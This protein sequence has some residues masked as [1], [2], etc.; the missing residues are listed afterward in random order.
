M[1]AL[2][3]DD[4]RSIARDDAATPEICDSAKTAAAR[5]LAKEAF[6]Q[7]TTA[8]DYAKIQG[9]KQKSPRRWKRRGGLVSG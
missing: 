6:L 4:A 2:S 7:W 9:L 5:N 3:A 1:I 8:Q